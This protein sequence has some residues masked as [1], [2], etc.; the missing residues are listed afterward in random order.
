MDQVLENALTALT[1]RVNLATGLIHQLDSDSAKEMFKILNSN[2]VNLDSNEIE[3][4][5][6]LMVG[7][8]KMP[9]N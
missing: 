5:A 3:Y 6:S 2:G 9:K 7:K 4:W 8:L 1:R